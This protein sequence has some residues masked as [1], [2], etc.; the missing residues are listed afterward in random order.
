[1]ISFQSFGFGKIE[2]KTVAYKFKQCVVWGRVAGRN[3][4]VGNTNT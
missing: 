4:M 1:M 2:G 3:T